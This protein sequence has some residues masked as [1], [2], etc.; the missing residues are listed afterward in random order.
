[1]NET[2]RCLS[3]DCEQRVMNLYGYLLDYVNG[4]FDVI[5]NIEKV[6]DPE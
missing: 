4:R 5:E 6:A 1:M 2:D 3:E